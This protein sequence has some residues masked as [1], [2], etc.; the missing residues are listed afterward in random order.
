MRNHLPATSVIHI[1]YIGLHTCPFKPAVCLEVHQ[2]SIYAFRS[3]HIDCTILSLLGLQGALHQAPSK[4]KVR[5][6][7]IASPTLARGTNLQKQCPSS[8]NTDRT[9]T[10]CRTRVLHAH[11]M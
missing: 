1:A 9:N 5:R 8:K 6:E 11:T 3:G 7:A 4:R 2:H 10:Q